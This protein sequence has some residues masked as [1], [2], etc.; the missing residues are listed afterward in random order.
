M[1]HPQPRLC[2]ERVAVC[3]TL[4]KG[5]YLMYREFAAEVTLGIYLYIIQR[6]RSPPPRLFLTNPRAYSKLVLD[7][8]GKAMCKYVRYAG[9]PGFAWLF[10]QRTSNGSGLLGLDALMYHVARSTSHKTNYVVYS[11]QHIALHSAMHPK[12]RTVAEAMM[13]VSALGRKGS[14]MGFDRFQEALNM[15]QEQRDGLGGNFDTKLHCGPELATLLHGTHAYDEAMGTDVLKC[16][17]P[18]RA[19]LLNGAVRIR[20]AIEAK[21]GTDI[22]HPNPHNAFWHTGTSANMMSG[23]AMLHRPWKHCWNVADGTAMGKGPPHGEHRRK[24]ESWER[25]YSRTVPHH[26][27]PNKVDDGA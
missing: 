20:D 12:I 14:A 23:D 10:C 11:A 25:H 26:M 19:S 27:R 22:S 16:R 15:V 18:I 9:V 2:A 8:G 17:D 13:S 4:D 6:C 24:A 7:A 1:T 3:Q 5:E 21:L